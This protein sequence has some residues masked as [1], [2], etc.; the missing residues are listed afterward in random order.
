MTPLPGIKDLAKSKNVEIRLFNIIY[1]LIDDLKEEL[2]K[3]LPLL[4]EEEILG[5]FM[6]LN[7]ITFKILY[8]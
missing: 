4:P 3:A 6:K 7:H 8:F 5:K 2:S 1:R